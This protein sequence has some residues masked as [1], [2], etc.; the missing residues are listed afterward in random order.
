MF[1]EAILTID[2]KLDE[3]HSVRGAKETINMI[4]FHGEA[5]SDVFDGRILPG[6]VDTQFIGNDGNGMLS[7]RYMLEG[8]D[9]CGNPCRIFIHNQAQTGQEAPMRTVPVVV[10]DSPVL[11]Y[12]EKAE[13]EGE[14]VGTED[15]VC[16]TVRDKVVPFERKEHVLE[17]GDRRIYGELYVP[18]DGMEKHPLLIASHGYNGCC[19]YMRDEMAEVVKRGIAVYC[20][21]F[22]GGGNKSRS[23][24]KT[25]E[26]SVKTEMRDL[27]D[28]LDA[29]TQLECVD[30]QRVYLYGSSQGGFIS[31]LVAP[32]VQE[33]IRG[34]FLQFP[35]FCIPDD[36]NDKKAQET[37]DK[38]D[39]MGMEIGRCY[40]DDLPEEDVFDIAARY[41]GPAVIFHGDADGLVKLKYSEKLAE[42]YENAKL[43]VYPEQGHGFSE[44]FLKVMF[45]EIVQK[46]LHD[47]V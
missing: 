17:L 18:L 27:R 41:A 23:T 43:Y 35:A 30:T 6:G 21:D 16:I 44:P 38:F 8:K 24:G 12:L 26:M 9:V 33:R 36:W 42:K 11:Q 5:H 29:M 1:D 10:T 32:E 2:V 19:E 34:I 20:Y 22:C 15:G 13:L 31:G 45:G 47:G 28:V 39:F 4:C 7:A 37:P 3:S 25:W 40:I 46:I 14:L